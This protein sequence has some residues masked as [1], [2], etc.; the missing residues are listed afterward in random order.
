MLS[1]DMAFDL[2]VALESPRNNPLVVQPRIQLSDEQ[3][4]RFW[5]KTVESKAPALKE[6]RRWLTAGQALRVRS[7][8]CKIWTGYVGKG[9]PQFAVNGTAELAHRAIY[10]HL[11]GA[12]PEG[13]EL[14]HL[15]M[16]KTCVEPVHLEAVT[17][18]ENLRRAAA[19][20]PRAIVCLRGH[21]RTPDN[22]YRNGACRTCDRHRRAL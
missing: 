13:Y 22:L 19:A 21:S 5:T 14:D 11:I 3:L 12:I 1:A 20:R 6:L 7:A 8:T 4:A 10:E 15:C 18:S 9:Y 2:M 17:G 16:R